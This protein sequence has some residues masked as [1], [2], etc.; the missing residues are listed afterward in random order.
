MTCRD[1]TDVIAVYPQLRPRDTG[2]N[3]QVGTLCIITALPAEAAPLVAHRSLAWQRQA[4]FHYADGDGISILVGGIGKL[5]ASVSVARYCQWRGDVE[6]VVNI[7]IGGSDRTPGSV[8]LAHV[9]VDAGSGWRFHPQLPAARALP[10]IDTVEVVTVDRPTTDY[11]R[12]TVFD[13]EAA[14]VAAAARA[15]VGNHAL[16]CLKV[17][18]DGPDAP[19]DALD[20]SS[21]ERLIGDQLTV[22]DQLIACLLADSRRTEAA[23]LQ[24]IDA[25]CDAIAARIRHTATQ[26]HQLQRRLQ[27]IAAL[28]GEL[29]APGLLS[30]RDARALAL[31]LEQRLAALT[32][33]Y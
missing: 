11:R 1:V 4:G 10:A 20:K 14:G 17:V 19:L 12:D 31:L 30:C 16:Q 13:M 22:V 18:S 5:A 8:V 6:A 21:V 29:P 27:R 9:V 24:D 15:F 25:L 2:Y 33:S 32:L 28:G 3:E 26:R 7:G 23:L